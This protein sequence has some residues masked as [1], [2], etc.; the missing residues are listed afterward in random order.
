MV[1]TLIETKFVI[2]IYIRKHVLYFADDNISMGTNMN[3]PFGK[4]DLRHSIRS[5]KIS[6]DGDVEHRFASYPRGVYKS[7]DGRYLRHE[8][9]VTRGLYTLSLNGYNNYMERRESTTGYN[10]LPYTQSHNI[11]P[12]PNQYSLHFQYSHSQNQLYQPP[13]STSVVYNYPLPKPGFNQTL[14]SHHSPTQRTQHRQSSPNINTPKM[15]Y[16]QTLDPNYRIYPEMEQN[17]HQIQPHQQYEHMTSGL[18]GYWKRLESG[19]TVWCNSSPIENASWQRDKRFGS[20]D[21]RKNKRLHKR[22]SPSVD[23]KSATLATV[24]TYAD[25]VRTTALKSPQVS[26]VTILFIL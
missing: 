12:P 5:S 11:H 6:S 1:E 10:T 4:N 25:H 13:R 17:P 22:V 24:P 26:L 8:D 3:E 2:Y 15:F 7:Y 14:K 21:R 20:L 23:N 9:S 19:E 16:S 18:G